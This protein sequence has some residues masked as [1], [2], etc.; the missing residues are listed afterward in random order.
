[1]IENDGI[2]YYQI[3]SSMIEHFHP[4]LMMKNHI[5]PKNVLPISVETRNF[6]FIF[7]EIKDFPGIE[8]SKTRQ[9]S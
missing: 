3:L 7:I 8:K 6:L 5:Q 2:I 4:G 1:M 9:L